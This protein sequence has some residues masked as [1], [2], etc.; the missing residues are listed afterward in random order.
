M[1]SPKYSRRSLFSSLVSLIERW[2][3]AVLYSASF[4]GLYPNTPFNCFLKVEPVC[5]L[6]GFQKS[7]IEFESQK[8]KSRNN[9]SKEA[10]TF[11]I[12]FPGVFYLYFLKITQAL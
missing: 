8:L 4:P 7:T 9:Y 3:N 2:V 1:A 6:K 10:T 5:F 12:A 11:S